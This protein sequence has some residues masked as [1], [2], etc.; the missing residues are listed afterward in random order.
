V[1]IQVLDVPLA[2]VGD[3]AGAIAADGAWT[4]AVAEA[5]A[6]RVVAEAAEH[7]KG[8]D[9]LVLARHI[10]TPADLARHNPNLGPGDHASGHNALS[11]GFTQRPIPA[12]G[13]GYATTVPGLYLIGA[14]TWP[15]P[16]VSGSSG[17]A[18]AQALLS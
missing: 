6:D 2:P 7:L 12:H 13:G 9:D 18:V 1:R 8:L 15:G 14:A 10:V 16:G 17:R 5:F 3:A 11:Q 4:S